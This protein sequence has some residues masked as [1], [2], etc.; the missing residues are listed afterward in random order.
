M[1]QRQT[2]I[3]FTDIMMNKLFKINN[4]GD[5]YKYKRNVPLCAVD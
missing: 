4:K 1:K 5:K 3:L 2:N